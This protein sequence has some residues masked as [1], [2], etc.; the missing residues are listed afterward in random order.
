IIRPQPSTTRAAAE[1][2]T[3]T[4]SNLE[5]VSSAAWGSPPE[6]GQLRLRQRGAAG[7][8]AQCGVPDVLQIGDA[9]L[10]GIKTVASHSTQES[11]KGHTL[12][13]GWIVLRILL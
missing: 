13:Q 9:D 7:E 3:R 6:D 12:A 11:K 8:F 5:D 2:R 10:A 4:N 1:N